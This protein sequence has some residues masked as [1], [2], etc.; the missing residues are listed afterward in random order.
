[1]TQYIGYGKAPGAEYGESQTSRRCNDD[2]APPL[3]H[4]RRYEGVPLELVRLRSKL[5]LGSELLDEIPDV[6]ENVQE[7]DIRKGFDRHSLVDGTLRRL[8]RML[9]SISDTSRSALKESRILRVD[10]VGMIKLTRTAG[11]TMHAHN[12][13]EGFYPK[14]KWVGWTQCRD[15]WFLRTSTQ[16]PA[17]DTVRSVDALSALWWPR[18]DEKGVLRL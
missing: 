17:V 16:R 13:S 6:I 14:E 11:D 8:P 5:L 18:K 10:D 2:L 9:N 4:M 7:Y 3:A 1:M 12:L 15:Q